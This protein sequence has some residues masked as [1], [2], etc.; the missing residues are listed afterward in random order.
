MANQVDEKLLKTLQDDGYFIVNKKSI[1]WG[2]SILGFL[3]VSLWGFL[4]NGISNNSNKADQVNRTL[5]ELIIKLE[6]KKVNPLKDDVGDIKGDIK[7]ILDRTNSRWRNNTNYN[8]Y[9]VMAAP[10]PTTNNHISDSLPTGL[11]SQ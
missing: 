9:P 11:N 8:S 6:E 3:L 4:Q 1:K 2:L 10:V 5:K 7:V